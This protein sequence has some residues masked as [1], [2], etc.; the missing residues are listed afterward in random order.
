MKKIATH[1]S[2][3][4]EE[5]SGLLS[6]LVT[7]FS[8]CQSKTLVE[9]YKAGVRYFDIRVR[10]KARGFV[11][12]HGLWESKKLVL[13]LLGELDRR[14]TE[15]CYISLTYEGDTSEDIMTALKQAV[16]SLCP[17]LK[18]VYVAKK[19]PQWTVLEQYKAVAVEQCY[20]VLDFSTWHTLLPLPRLWQ[21]VYYRDVEF[22]EETFKMVDFI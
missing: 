2:A 15:D 16:D 18:V 13:T 1:N 12:A 17:R 3:T 9:Q 20:K 21:K 5:G 10:Q 19:R 4:G 8:K 22:N 6:W 14:A 7:P 11:C